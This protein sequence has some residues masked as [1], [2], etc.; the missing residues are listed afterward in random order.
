MKAEVARLFPAACISYYVNGCFDPSTYKYDA[1]IE[2]LSKCLLDSVQTYTPPHTHFDPLTEPTVRPFPLKKGLPAHVKVNLSV[3]DLLAGI[4]KEGSLITSMNEYTSLSMFADTI[5]SLRLGL[6]NDQASAVLLNYFSAHHL[7]QNDACSYLLYTLM[8]FIDLDYSKWCSDICKTTALNSTL[9]G[10][11]CVEV[12]GFIGRGCIG[13]DL[14]A[15]ALRRCDDAGRT[16]GVPFNDSIR[17]AIDFVI[18]DS[19]EKQSP[20]NTYNEHID[21]LWCNLANGAHTALVEKYGVLKGTHLQ[22]YGVTSLHKK[23]VLECLSDDKAYI[24]P[25]SAMLQTSEKLE[26]GKTRPIYMVDLMTHSMFSYLTRHVQECSREKRIILNPGDGGTV[27][28]NNV[29]SRR[30]NDGMVSV[31]IDYSDFNSQHSLDTIKYLTSA[32][33]DYFGFDQE[34][35][36]NLITNWDNMSCYYH[37]NYVGKFTGSLPSGHAMTTVVN[38]ILNAAYVRSCCPHLYTQLNSYHVGDD[39]QVMVRGLTPALYIVGSLQKAGFRLNPAKQSI[40]PYGC[41]FLRT[42]HTTTHSY[43]YVARSIASFVSGNWSNDKRLDPL[44]FMNTVV[45]GVRSIINRSANTNSGALLA[46]T[47]QQKTQLSY[48][49]CRNMLTGRIAINNGPMYSQMRIYTSL[50]IKYDRRDDNTKKLAAVKSAILPVHPH[51]ATTRYLRTSAT[52]LETD[53]M[54]NYKI[55]PCSAMLESSLT[56]DYLSEFDDGYDVV[57]H[58]GF[59]TADVTNLPLSA[60]ARRKPPINYVD[61]MPL[62]RI[63]ISKGRHID[64]VNTIANYFGVSRQ[65]IINDY[66]FKS[67]CNS[68]I[69]FFLPYN[70]ACQYG[71]VVT[72]SFIFSRCNYYF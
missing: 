13:E 25:T 52:S 40:G 41:E 43:G 39:V 15:D 2:Y 62:L 1:S 58:G 55:N 67:N 60:V 19:F 57:A 18:K 16:I 22:R 42:C 72:N 51:N 35:T 12:A 50:T 29:F 48:I 6:Y 70:D 71:S 61:S 49:N 11:A 3:T 47:L 46:Y 64:V 10:A 66:K 36:S 59:T 27:K 44:N 28:F 34:Y 37:G 63:L 31:G 17:E 38:T 7:F 68:I 14:Y 56:K 54:R 20:R 65:R 32:L 9:A 23:S 30:L 8:P 26:H 5:N 45:S 24:Q 69:S 4:N 33:C 53:L 21:S